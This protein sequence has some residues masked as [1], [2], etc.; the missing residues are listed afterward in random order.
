MNA[1]EDDPSPSATDAP[2]TA[3]FDGVYGNPGSGDV[4]VGHD[5]A[6]ILSP[7]LSMGLN[8]TPETDSWLYGEIDQLAPFSAASLHVE[9]GLCQFDD[10]DEATW[11]KCPGRWK[12]LASGTAESGQVSSDGTWDFQAQLKHNGSIDF[13]PF[14]LNSNL[15][16]EVRIIQSPGVVSES[17]AAPRLVVAKTWMDLA[18]DEYT[19]ASPLTGLSAGT[20]VPKGLTDA[21]PMEEKSAPF[22]S[23]GFVIMAAL[24]AVTFRRR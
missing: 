13:V 8:F 2:V 6:F 11:K 15:I 5:W 1:V 20:D 16:L 22:L 18:L 23:V 21:P 10:A 4:G 9:L 24:A 19:E 7:A 17:D 3:Q 12:S 14:T